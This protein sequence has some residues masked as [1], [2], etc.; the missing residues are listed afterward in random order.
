MQPFGILAKIEKIL[1]K[2]EEIIAKIYRGKA[3]I[4]MTLRCLGDARRL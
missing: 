3:F 1:A 2:I 4:G